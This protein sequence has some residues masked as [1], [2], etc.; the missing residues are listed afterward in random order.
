MARKRRDRAPHRGR[1][2][3]APLLCGG[4]GVTFAP[5]RPWHRHCSNRCRARATRARRTHEVQAMIAELKRLA[6]R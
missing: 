3:L 2:R 4:C 6:L 1:S 5:V